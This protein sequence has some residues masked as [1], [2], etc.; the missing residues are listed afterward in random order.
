MIRYLVGALALACCIPPAA[1]ARQPQSSVRSLPMQFEWRQEGPAEACGAKCRSWIAAIGTITADTPQD[2]DEFVRERDAHGATLVLDSGGGSVHGAMALGRQIRKLGIT[3]R[4]GRTVLLAGGSASGRHARLS[5]DAD[6]E[7]MCAFVLLGG[8]KREVP[9]GAR[10]MVHQIWLGDR[11]DDAVAATYSAEDLV[12]VQRDIGR[13]AIYTIEMGGN[14][15]L[16]D[17][18]LR[19]PPWEPMR[20]LTRAEMLRTKL[21]AGDETKPQP[22]PAVASVAATNAAVVSGPTPRE[23]KGPRGW[24]LVEAS[25]RPMLTREHPLTV[26]GEEIGS[27]EV[28][29]TCTADPSTFHVSYGERRQI[30]E[31]VTQ[32]KAVSLSVGSRSAPLKVLSSDLVSS[33]IELSTLAQGTVSAAMLRSFSGTSRRA[34]LVSTRSASDARTTIRVGNSGITRAFSR[35]AA[36][37]GGPGN[38][39]HAN[40]LRPEPR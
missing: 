19:R 14:I 16:L 36:R 4:V 21:I 35:L 32:L 30:I 39:A 23:A 12:L 7:S 24:T 31:G 33:S 27:F 6:C 1:D 10:I 9:T 29:I 25:G 38:A 18:S 8:A 28:S 20:P 5:A 22:A 11:R 17:L 15:E 34:L 3:T 13:L 26:D 40:L 2:F 37:C